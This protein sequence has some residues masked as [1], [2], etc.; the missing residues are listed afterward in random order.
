[1]SEQYQLVIAPLAEQ[2]LKDIES[3]K[4]GTVGAQQAAAFIDNPLMDSV[5]KISQDSERYRYNGYLSERGLLKQLENIVR[6]SAYS[7]VNYRPFDL[8]PLLKTE[9]C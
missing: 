9:C 3:Y 7:T 1:M 6:C 5:E 4:C 8:L 2:C